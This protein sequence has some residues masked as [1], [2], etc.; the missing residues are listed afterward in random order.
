MSN[1]FENQK[2]F[3]F[4]VVF[5]LKDLI[6]YKKYTELMYYVYS[7]SVKYPKSEKVVLFQI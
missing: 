7:V 5:M 2:L 1:Y 3:I 4:K 6:L